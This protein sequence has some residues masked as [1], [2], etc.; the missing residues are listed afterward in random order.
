MAAGTARTARL[1]QLVNE[2]RAFA[3]AGAGYRTE[4][5][6]ST[7]PGDRL[8]AVAFLGVAPDASSLTWLSERFAVERP[9]IQFHAAIALRAAA[10]HLPE[11]D[12][13]AVAK[14]IDAAKDIVAQK[15][16]SDTA[17]DNALADAA[18]AVAGRKSAPKQKP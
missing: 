5:M 6:G 1:D 7:S 15:G 14:A 13:D 12:L 3:A 18:R 8:L 17:R 10:E 9:F 11:G 16:L 4:L 2:M